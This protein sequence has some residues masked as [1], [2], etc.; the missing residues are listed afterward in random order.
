M[1]SDSSR[2]WLQKQHLLLPLFVG[3]EIEYAMRKAG[4]H[5][6]ATPVFVNSGARSGWL[7]GTVTDRV[8]QQGDLIVI[9]LVPRFH[10]YCANMCRTFVVGE[11]S[12]EQ[13]NMYATY[14]AAQAAAV[15][16]MK[17][18][19]KMKMVDEAAKAVFDERGYGNYYV[20]GISHSI[21]LT[22][23]ETPMPTIHPAHVNYE[24]ADGM[25]ITAGHSV[26][27]V[28]GIGGVRIE[29]TYRLS[30][31]GMEAL[32]TYSQELAVIA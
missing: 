6:T 5:G 28:P 16:V 4:G 14:R 22:F 27:S 18:G 32:T 25:V 26:L 30:T 21:G 31:S 13:M 3:A 12:K 11:P 20:Y 29:D 19:L 24:L 1:G 17:P 8:I 23:E 7:H 9:D 15:S 10:G 2:H